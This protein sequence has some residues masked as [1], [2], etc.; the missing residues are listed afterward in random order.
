MGNLTTF[1]QLRMVYNNPSQSNSPNTD[2]ALTSAFAVEGFLLLNNN[3]APIKYLTISNSNEE[4]H[5]AIEIKGTIVQ[6]A[7]TVQNYK[8]F[9]FRQEFC[10]GGASPASYFSVEEI[11]TPLN[12]DL[13]PLEPSPL[14]D[15][16]EVNNHILY[17]ESDNTFECYLALS[18]NSPKL[19]K[20]TYL[21]I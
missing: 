15:L 20:G 17:N 8:S 11:N 10:R 1:S 5:I 12:P 2:Y 14:Y 3:D 7:T 19:I 18:N 9:T 6:P 13:P 21:L 4:T 16:T